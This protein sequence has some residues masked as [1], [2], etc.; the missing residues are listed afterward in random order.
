[1][2]CSDTAAIGTVYH[3][4]IYSLMDQ[5]PTEATPPGYGGIQAEKA[6]GGFM[7]NTKEVEH[8]VHQGNKV[9]DDAFDAMQHRLEELKTY[10]FD[11][12]SQLLNVPRNNLL[13]PIKASMFLREDQQR[14]LCGDWPQP[15]GRRLTQGTITCVHISFTQLVTTV[16]CKLGSKDRKVE[17]SKL[18]ERGRRQAPFILTPGRTISAILQCT[19]LSLPQSP[20]SQQLL[21]P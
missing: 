3:F 2:D 21:I 18:R 1:M 13:G 14:L 15:R 5:P 8:S 20:V 7:T 6:L 10:P 19:R 4:S 9:G 16:G 17:D 11:E 12:G